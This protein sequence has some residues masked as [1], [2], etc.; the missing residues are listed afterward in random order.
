MGEIVTILDMNGDRLYGQRVQVKYR[1][2]EGWVSS[3]FLKQNTESS[4]SSQNRAAP[5]ASATPAAAP[6]ASQSQ[7]GA[8]APQT[9]AQQFAV[10]DK[11]FAEGY[12][13]IYYATITALRDNG[14]ADVR[15]YDNDTASSTRVWA[16]QDIIKTHQAEGNP[17]EGKKGDCEVL[18]L[19]SGEMRV[20][21]TGTG[22][23][24]TLPLESVVFKRQ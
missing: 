11:V 9:P 3:S 23:E 24:E 13:Y 12:R 1:N 15:F 7:S 4:A 16:T 22:A 19:E 20:R 8:A 2:N 14:T 6:A 18:A 21:F 17:Y 5:A 10:G